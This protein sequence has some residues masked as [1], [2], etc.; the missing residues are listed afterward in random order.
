MKKKGRR[1]FFPS[2]YIF[3]GGEGY[4]IPTVQLGVPGGKDIRRMS[5]PFFPGRCLSFGSLRR[6][7]CCERTNLQIGISGVPRSPTPYST[8]GAF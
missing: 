8:R 3:S 4:G 5:V 2:A 1:D 7:F 6:V